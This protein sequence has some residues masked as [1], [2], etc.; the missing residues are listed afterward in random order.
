M[1]A[2]N[3]VVPYEWE[4]DRKRFTLTAKEKENAEYILKNHSQYQYTLEDDQFVVY[5]TFHRIIFVN[6]NEAIQKHNRLYIPMYNTI[7][8]VDVKARAINKEGKAVYFEG[9]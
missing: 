3:G 8:L 1:L 4:K 9:A 6:S 2:A 7:E 5:S